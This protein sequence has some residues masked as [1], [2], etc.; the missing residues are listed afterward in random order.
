[1]YFVS[2]ELIKYLGWWTNDEWVQGRVNIG[3]NDATKEGELKGITEDKFKQLKDY[4][5]LQGI[6]VQGFDDVKGSDKF[7]H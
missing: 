2:D 1:M 3:L 5:T 7:K 6:K 4:A